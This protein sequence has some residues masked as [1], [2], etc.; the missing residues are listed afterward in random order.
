[1]SKSER[2]GAKQDVD[3]LE[4]LSEKLAVDLRKNIRQLV[5]I[6]FSL[7]YPSLSIPCVNSAHATQRPS[8]GKLPHS[9]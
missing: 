4:V 3:E 7:A 2:Y 5:S 6:Y 9:V 8:P 1:M